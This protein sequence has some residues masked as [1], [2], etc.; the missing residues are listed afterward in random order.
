MVYVLFWVD[1]PIKHRNILNLSHRP[2]KQ[3]AALHL[4]L[5]RI[6]VEHL[7][8]D[9]VDQAQTSSRRTLRAAHLQELVVAIRYL[10]IRQQIEI[11]LLSHRAPS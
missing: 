2:L 8:R 11:Y 9:L 7:A 6:L 1:G 3:S 4:V 5:G 10:L